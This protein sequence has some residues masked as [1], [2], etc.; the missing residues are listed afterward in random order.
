MGYVPNDKLQNYYEIADLFV[1][2]STTD[3]FG[4]VILEAQAKGLYSIVTDVGGP[5]EIIENGHTG[6]VLSLADMG[7][8]VDKIHEIYKMKTEQPDNFAAMQEACRKLIET[9]FN[10]N[11]AIFDI[12]GE[13]TSKRPSIE[14][15][16]PDNQAKNISSPSYEPNTLKKVVA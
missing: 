16:F 15:Y 6:S 14:E 2:P 4:M 9:K 13:E 5:Q 7:S 8:W 1:F 3:T 10:W 12:L 11:D